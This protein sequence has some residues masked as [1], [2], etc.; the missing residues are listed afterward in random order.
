MIFDT[1]DNCE[2]YFKMHESFELAFEFIK[3]VLAGYTTSNK[4]ALKDMDVYAT[5]SKYTTHEFQMYEAHKKYIDIQFIIK[6]N[7]QMFYKPTSECV[8]KTDYNAD[9]DCVMLTAEEPTILEAKPGMF[10][11]F[12]PEDAHAP[13]L[14]SGEASYVHKVVVKVKAD[15]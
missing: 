15:C 13:G 6:G 2:K 4:Y 10:A 11:I 12:Y 3:S 8:A 9:K 14:I 5:L 1:L 7:E